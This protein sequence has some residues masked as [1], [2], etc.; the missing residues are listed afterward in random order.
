MWLYRVVL[1]IFMFLNIFAGF[2]RSYKY[3]YTFEDDE[4]FND[5]QDQPVGVLN[6]KGLFNF[7]ELTID[8]KGEDIYVSGNVT[9]IWN[10]Q[11]N[12]RIQVISKCF[13]FS[14]SIMQ[15]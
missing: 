15:T 12:D 7:S 4:I 3:K 11:P 8:L 2:S 1:V 5:C 14:N 9:S 6:V 10:V 13:F